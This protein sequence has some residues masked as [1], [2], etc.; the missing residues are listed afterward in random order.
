M[1]TELQAIPFASSQR[2]Q[3]ELDLQHTA[4]KPRLASRV[5]KHKPAAVDMART[6]VTQLHDLPSDVGALLSL[7]SSHPTLPPHSKRVLS[8][9]LQIPRGSFTTYGILS[10]HVGSSPRAVGGALRRNPFAPAVPCH[11][12]VATGGGLGGFK[13]KME[14]RDG[15][16]GR[17]TLDEKRTLL[18]EE[19][20]RFDKGK[21]DGEGRVVGTPW[22][23]FV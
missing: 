4:L 21:G 1:A 22:E 15:E 19:G 3:Q 5:S 18:R 2:Q 10:A 8:A 12:V 14:V 7:I 9:L 20:V 17:L 11:R 16:R 23:G 13:G 6:R